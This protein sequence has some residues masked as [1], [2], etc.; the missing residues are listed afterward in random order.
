MTA[1]PV[2]T[3]T[4]HHQLESSG[5]TIK[6]PTSLPEEIWKN[7]IVDG[8]A[9]INSVTVTGGVATLNLKN[10]EYELRL[11]KVTL[12]TS[13]EPDATYLKSEDPS[14]PDETIDATVG[15]SQTFTV[16]VRDEFGNLYTS[17]DVTVSASTTGDG[18]LT[19]TSGVSP[20]DEARAT[21]TYKPADEDAG[22]TVEVELSINGG[23]EEH[24]TV[25]YE[26]DV[27]DDDS[28]SGSSVSVGEID[29]GYGIG[30]VIIG[31]ESNNNDP[32]VV[33]FENRGDEQ[34]TATKVRL[35][36]FAA[37]GGIESG[38]NIEIEGKEI[39]LNGDITPLGDG[40]FP[41]RDGSEFQIPGN[42]GTTD[43]EI[44]SLGNQGGFLVMDVVFVTDNGEEIVGTYAVT[45]PN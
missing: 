27:S 7:E 40:G 36:G 18:D 3:S 6:V 8:A 42:G 29:N 22:N 9:G 4:E 11:T 31:V 33:E 30:V 16:S 1:T 2:S 14:N 5:G 26:M 34:V 25:T 44:E 24:E 12:G 32:T 38:E 37:Q 45:I 39:P 28:D 15:E 21:F 19:P 41:T 43:I 13:S 20:D 23:G 17:D 35:N 10:Q